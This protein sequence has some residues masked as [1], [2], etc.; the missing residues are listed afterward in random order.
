MNVEFRKLCIEND[1]WGCGCVCVWSNP[2]SEDTCLVSTLYLKRGCTPNR[3]P[4]TI[5]EIEQMVAQSILRFQMRVKKI[6]RKYWA[7]LWVVKCRI[8]T[9]YV[10]HWNSWFHMRLDLCVFLCML[11]V[12][13]RSSIDG[14]LCVCVCLHDITYI[15]GHYSYTNDTLNLM[16]HVSVR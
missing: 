10:F 9:V 3:G 8:E 1:V 13:W 14:T 4:S 15:F 11:F 6:T 2:A 12:N 5:C 16:N 7:P